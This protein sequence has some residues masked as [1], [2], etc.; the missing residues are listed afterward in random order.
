MV[1][2]SL[3]IGKKLKCSLV[4]SM[5]TIAKYTISNPHYTSHNN[6]KVKNIAKDINIYIYIYTHT[7][8]SEFKKMRKS[9]TI[10]IF[11]EN[12]K[13]MEIPRE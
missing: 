4:F 11:I 1:V 9:G 12:K 6:F 8:K 3:D 5:A 13:E 7:E 2:M 10:I